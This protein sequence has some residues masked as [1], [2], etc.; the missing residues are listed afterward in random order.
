MLHLAFTV[1]CEHLPRVLPFLDPSRKGSGSKAP[2]RAGRV[3]LRYE[4]PPGAVRGTLP[5][6][7][8]AALS[9]DTRSDSDINND[10]QDYVD[11]PQSAR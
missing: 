5:V 4:S 9:F 6:C 10:P 2:L 11:L 3:Y 1:A 8:E 7:H